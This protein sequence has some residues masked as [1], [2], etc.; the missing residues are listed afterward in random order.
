MEVACGNLSRSRCTFGAVQLINSSSVQD[1]T[2]EFVF[3]EKFNEL[4][5]G[6]VDIVAQNGRHM[7]LLYLRVWM[8]IKELL[9]QHYGE[10]WG[11]IFDKK[12]C[13]R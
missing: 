5:R 2:V 11:K 10:S 12:F 9:N 3:S 13:F 6:V 4:K 8:G 1:F 7:V